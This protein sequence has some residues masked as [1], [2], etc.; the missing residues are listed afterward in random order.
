MRVVPGPHQVLSMRVRAGEVVVMHGLC[1]HGGSNGR[2]GRSSIR[3]HWYM[4]EADLAT[5]EYVKEGTTYRLRSYGLE[6]ARKLGFPPD[7]DA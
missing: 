2:R 6:M 7:R 5:A 4:Q 3:F 1:V